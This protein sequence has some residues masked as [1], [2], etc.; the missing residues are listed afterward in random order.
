MDILVNFR[1]FQD[2]IIEV[3]WMWMIECSPE[4]DLSEVKVFESVSMDSD[5]TVNVHY[6]D[7]RDGERGIDYLLFSYLLSNIEEDKPCKWFEQLSKK[8][9]Q[10]GKKSNLPAFDP[11]TPEAGSPLASDIIIEGRR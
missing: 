5:S 9:L 4:G 7:K 1:K 11:V 2:K 6:I 3:W 10:E 8:M